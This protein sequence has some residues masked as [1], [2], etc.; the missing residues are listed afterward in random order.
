MQ[1][2]IEMAQQAQ[3]PTNDALKNK[4]ERR[5][6]VVETSINELSAIQAQVNNLLTKLEDYQAS[7]DQVRFVVRGFN[8]LPY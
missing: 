6:L 5:D 7:E 4:P 8:L 2:T 1:H 3:G